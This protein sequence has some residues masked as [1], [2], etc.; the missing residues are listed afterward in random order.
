MRIEEEETITLPQIDSAIDRDMQALATVWRREMLHTLRDK[1]R[2]VASLIQPVLFLLIIGNGMAPAVGQMAGGIDFKKFMFPGIICMSVL[3]SSIFYGITVVSDRE[4]GFLK[5]ILV[6]PVRRYVVALGKILAGATISVVPALIVLM[7][8]PLLAGVS[9]SLPMVL[10]LI[11]FLLLLAVLL[12]SLGVAMGGLIKSMAAFQVIM[13]VLVLPLFFLSGGI[14][15]LKN[16]PTWMDV[17][18]KINPLTYGVDPIR[19]IGLT[20][21][22][23]SHGIQ[24]FAVYSIGFD[25]YMLLVFAAIM[26]AAAIAVFRRL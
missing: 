9:L 24:A 25:I 16:L 10:K 22:L 21:T 4:F 15:P 5:E 13:T 8:I 12:T 3:F 2:L 1:G 23:R 6:A 18:S 7:L 11:P 26:I 19:Q 17:L 14:F 20:T